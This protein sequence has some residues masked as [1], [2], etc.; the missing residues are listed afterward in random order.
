MAL[1]H[2]RE[3]I[4]ANA[5]RPCDTETPMLD[6]ELRAAG[7][8]PEAGRCEAGE[9]I[10]MGPVATPSEVARHIADAA[11]PVDGGHTAV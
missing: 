7:L 8:E 10:P 4:R 1:D 6:A 11:L 3:A 9:A 5:V 2:G